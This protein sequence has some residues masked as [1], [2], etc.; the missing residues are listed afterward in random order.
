MKTIGFTLVIRVFAA[1]LLAVIASSCSPQKG[2]RALVTLQVPKS[3]P[4]T[5]SDASLASTVD[6]TLTCFGVNVTGPGMPANANGCGLSVG[7]AS[8]MVLGGCQISL[9]VPRGS[10]RRVELFRYELPIGESACPAWTPANCSNRVLCSTLRS[11]QADGVNI[12]SGEATVEITLD[13]N[14]STPVSTAP[15]CGAGQLLVVVHS[16]GRV[17]NGAD[18]AFNPDVSDAKAV[19]V[20]IKDGMVETW[21][22]A[23]QSGSLSVPPHVTSVTRKPDSRQLYGLIGTNELVALDG[24]G[25]WS[26]V[27]TCPFDTCSVPPFMVSIS[28]GF[29]KAL[30]GLDAGGGLYKLTASGPQKVLD[31]SPTVWSVVYY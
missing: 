14:T 1:S 4:M 26:A 27:T 9:E 5:K 19:C 28:A 10:G 16:D 11:G 17:T 21:N 15:V 13:L 2:D 23:G 18:G 3:A 31:L 20:S 6:L 25:S 22:V 29:D 8:N 12:D 7:A 24:N 30:Y